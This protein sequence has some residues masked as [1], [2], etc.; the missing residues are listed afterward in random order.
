MSIPSRPA[1]WVA[2]ALAILLALYTAWSGLSRLH[3]RRAAVHAAQSDAEASAIP[4]SDLVPQGGAYRAGTR[5]IAAEA[6]R[7]RLL[8]A[9]VERRLL[10][11][12]VAIEPARRDASAALVARIAVSGPEAQVLQ[13]AAAVERARP[14][15]RLTDWRLQSTSAGDGTIRLDGHVS[16]LWQ[17]S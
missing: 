9:A 10:V 6:F 7:L 13:Y 4:I 1:L 14:L 16:A 15:A 11:E 2:A 3:E 5:D 17:G 12:R 8:E